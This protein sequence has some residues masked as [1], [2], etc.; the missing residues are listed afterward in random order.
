MLASSPL[1]ILKVLKF[2]RVGG[3]DNAK[4]ELSEITVFETSS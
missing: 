4:V 3:F 1:D 2:L